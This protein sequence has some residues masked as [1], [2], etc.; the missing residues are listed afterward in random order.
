MSIQ[1]K[2]PGVYIQDQKP[3]LETELAKFV[4]NQILNDL[5]FESKSADIIYINW[6]MRKMLAFDFTISEIKTEDE[7]SF[8]IKF[9]TLVDG[10]IKI[11][12]S[13]VKSTR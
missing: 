6:I 3:C 2:T 13:I 12:E 10:E 11:I 5:L 7:N 9:S 1:H 8:G 4:L